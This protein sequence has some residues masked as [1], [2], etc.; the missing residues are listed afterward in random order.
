[1]T[2]VILFTSSYERYTSFDEGSLSIELGDD[3]GESFFFDFSGE[4]ESVFFMEK[5]LSRSSRISVSEKRSLFV[6]GYMA[7]EEHRSSTTERYM[8]AFE[9]DTAR[10]DTFYFATGELYPC[11]KRLDDFVVKEGFFI[12]REGEVGHEDINCIKKSENSKF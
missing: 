9:I 12:L 6:R 2:L 4:L 3:T 8:R 7:G 10:S 5:E 1:M 11:F